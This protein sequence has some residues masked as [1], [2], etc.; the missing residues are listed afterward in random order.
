[1]LGVVGLPTETASCR[2]SPA[3]LQLLVTAARFCR[4]GD[5]R[6]SVDRTGQGE[7]CPVT[8]VPQGGLAWR[9]D[10]SSRSR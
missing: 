9:R 3:Q 4:N 8:T 5:N 7:Y 2:T 6:P 1:M 10:G